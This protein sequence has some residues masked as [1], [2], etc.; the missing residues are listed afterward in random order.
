MPPDKRINASTAATETRHVPLG[1]A[2]LLA[3]FQDEGK[4]FRNVSPYKIR[5]QLVSLLGSAVTQVAVSAIRSGALLIKTSNIDQTEVLLGW[6]SFAGNPIKVI[7]ADKLNQVEGM[8][9]APELVEETV[10]TILQESESQ[11]VTSVTRLPS[12]TGRPNPLIKI[13]FC[14][15]DLPD[16]FKAAYIR[17]EVRP[18]KT[19]PRRC[20]KC[21]RY[22]HGRQT[23]RARSQRCGRCA[24]DHDMQ[25]CEAPPLCAACEGPHPVTDRDC[26]V[27]V[28]KLEEMRAR[29][30]ATPSDTDETEWPVMTPPPPIASGEKR[31]P[32]ERR[33]WQAPPARQA[34]TTRQTQPERRV[35]PA[36]QAPPARQTPP[37]RQAP[38][39][40]QAR[41]ARSPE[42]GSPTFS[43]S[44]QAETQAAPPPEASSPA[45]SGGSEIELQT[46]ALQCSDYQ[47]PLSSRPGSAPQTVDSR[48]DTTETRT[49]TCPTTPSPKGSKR[50]MICRSSTEVATQP[51]GETSQTLL[52]S[53][54]LFP[55]HA[56]VLVT[57][58]VITS[59]SDHYQ[60][61]TPSSDGA[62][63]QPSRQYF[64]DSDDSTEYAS[65][66][67]DEATPKAASAVAAS[68]RTPSE[69][70]TESSP[71]TPPT[72][73]RS[74]RLRNRSSPCGQRSVG[75]RTQSQPPLKRSFI[76]D[77]SV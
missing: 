46:A 13:R 37:A 20:P 41:P 70:E 24:G 44:T 36:R 40:R 1:K 25:G 31:L 18:A 30:Q 62:N 60:R 42:V 71:P 56:S 58:P 27:W 45:P 16:H 7:P 2:F 19:L 22:G 29:S 67:E 17:Y 76:P 23:C 26:P 4:N 74:Q 21:L 11:M 66:S 14:M 48:H 34:P 43:T 73:R 35:P 65:S 15:T 49:D 47:T 28:H 64:L 5:D 38:P 59:I 8:V 52:P 54:P 3:R 33:A 32:T 53:H 55:P 72:Q 57:N 10:Q 68:P 12:K 75:Y 6:S 63:K 51:N 77:S 50:T 61:T 9:Y 69:S 39:V